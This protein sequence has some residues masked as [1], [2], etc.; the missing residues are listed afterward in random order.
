[1]RLAQVSPECDAKAANGISEAGEVLEEDGMCS[2]ASQGG[3][4]R[5]LGVQTWI[6]WLV[7]HGVALKLNRSPQ[8]GIRIE[9]GELDASMSAHDVGVELGS[10]P[11]LL[12]LAKPGV[13][14]INASAGD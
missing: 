6:G 4:L 1:M 7:G 3:E 2:A 12:L 5:E 10:I 13:S 9:T 8:G 11:P 14:L